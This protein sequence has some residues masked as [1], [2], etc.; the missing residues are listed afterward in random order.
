MSINQI[1]TNKFHL[2]DLIDDKNKELVPT[3]L[4]PKQIKVKKDDD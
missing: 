3:H 1:S 2:T 4:H